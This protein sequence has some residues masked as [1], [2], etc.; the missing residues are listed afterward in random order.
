MTKFP[1]EAGA[2]AAVAEL[3]GLYGP[4]S[5]SEKLLQ[6]IWLR[7]DFEKALART[8]DGRAVDVLDPGRWNLL[9]G[10]DFKSARLRIGGI[11]TT[12]DV[13]LHLHA[14]DWKAHGH[15]ADPAY[16]NVVLHVVLFAAPDAMTRGGAGNDVPILVLL[17]LLRHDLEEYAADAAVE[18]LAN[19]PLTRAREILAKLGPD[20]LRAQLRACAAARWEQKVKFARL[21]IER[22]GWE[23]AC[24][25][26]A[27]EILGYRFNRTPMLALATEFPLDRWRE[28]AGHVAAEALG[29]EIFAAIAARRQWS[30]QG[31]RPLNHPRLRLQQYA[32]WMTD[33]PDWPERLRR[34]AREI[35]AGL[36]AHA[37]LASGQMPPSVAVFR[38]V[39]RLGKVRERLARCVCGG[40]LGGTRFD[41]LTCDGFLP[42]LAADAVSHCEMLAALWRNWFVGDIPDNFLRTL[43]EL[44]LVGVKREPVSHG[45]L[46][47][48][49][50]WLLADEQKQR[51]GTSRTGRGT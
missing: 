11:L 13:E 34:A 27:L 32:R 36:S 19:H 4:F 48:L 31:V 45:I 33:A 17:P 8:T 41:N 3:Q 50:G 26:A 9:G 25:H 7:G 12:G 44:E 43:R 21:R 37:D 23:S 35:S 22:L 28:A 40:A 51:C 18:R 39:A 42:L 46:Q 47:G 16:A 49:I 29:D 1:G 30:L 20:D 24:H 5:F 6:Q 15:A 10:P 14:G 38:R 2:A